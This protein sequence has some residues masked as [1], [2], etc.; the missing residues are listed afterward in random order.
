MDKVPDNP[1]TSK[2]FS[3][4]VTRFPDASARSKTEVSTTLA[5]LAGM[6]GSASATTKNSLP[7]LKLARFGAMVS[8]AGSLRWARNMV[9]VSGVE[10]DYD[11]G[12]LEFDRAASLLRGS[13]LA[14]VIYTSPSYTGQAGGHRWRVLVPFSQ[15]ISAGPAAE[16]LRDMVLRRVE[17]ILGMSF[18]PESRV[19]AQGY[20]YGR[21]GVSP[22][23]VEY[24]EGVAGDAGLTVANSGFQPDPQLSVGN[25]FSGA[26]AE[27]DE[28][29]VRALLDRMPNEK[30]H[31][32]GLLW[33]DR[34]GWVEVGAALY[35]VSG[36]A[37]WCREL[38]AEWSRQW[39]GDRAE[40]ERVWDTFSDVR[41][42]VPKL[43]ELHD[44][45]WGGGS[46]V[47]V[48]AGL[49][50]PGAGSAFEELV[51]DAPPDPSK[52]AGLAAR[53]AKKYS[54]VAE[55]FKSGI[56]L[57]QFEPREFIDSRG[58]LLRGAVTL[59]AGPPGVAKSTFILNYLVALAADQ[60]I[61][62]GQIF[63]PRPVKVLYVSGDDDR[64][65]V[66]KRIAACEAQHAI[67]AGKF[68]VDVLA[69]PMPGFERFV[70][71]E[72][73]GKG[74]K[75]NQES[76]EALEDLVSSGKY[77]VVVVDPLANFAAAAEQSSRDFLPA[78]NRLV[79]IARQHEKCALVLVHHERKTQG[80]PGEASLDN[81]RGTGALGGAVRVARAMRRIRVDDL[82]ELGLAGVLT[83]DEVRR[84][85]VLEDTKASYQGLGAKWFL[86]IETVRF[87]NA[88]RGYAEDRV[89]VL[90]P[91]VAPQPQTV[92]LP[93]A[94]L[95]VVADEIDSGDYN[96]SNQSVGE[97][98]EA[99]GMPV[100]RV[101][102]LVD[103]L[104]RGGY[105]VADRVKT[106]GADGRERLRKRLVLQRRPTADD[107]ECND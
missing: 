84:L 81:A 52:T 46:G 4:L 10:G 54:L 23:K 64:D 6:I 72:A 104:E 32:A 99:V 57:D 35:G 44:S 27:L 2:G 24:M 41:S 89:G 61:F 96:Q 70:L 83:D 100:K 39:D 95:Q 13:G 59:L 50:R 102:A 1:A 21:A 31:P 12:V 88:R 22:F 98:A 43:L 78:M 48:L 16:A 93:V 63:G 19:A 94:D 91:W 25:V 75:L 76:F 67:P 38:W 29:E 60:T 40:A 15:E 20:Y 33:D 34:Q 65:E 73:D 97:L 105:I 66:W 11:A 55:R 45:V 79:G 80:Q 8:P 7:W 53:A 69:A 3:L 74:S 85:Y 26:G 86:K 9:G 107:A 82:E 14:H 42:G 92:S 106:P 51:L 36:G 90:V 101:R 58:L 49:K 77:D 103:A 47:G 28:F 18:A 71:V 5:Q 17:A 68:Q 56:A 30:G 37:A 87:G 62:T